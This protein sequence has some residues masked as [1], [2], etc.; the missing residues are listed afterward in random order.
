[1]IKIA[2]LLEK[3]DGVVA[4]R[5]HDTGHI[6]V[7]D[8]ETGEVLRD[9]PRG[10]WTDEELARWVLREDCE[11]IITGPME[12]RPFEIVAEEGMITRY[13][14]VGRRAPE[15]VRQMNACAL[16]LIPDYEGGVG[17]GAGGECH[18]HEH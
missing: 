6:C 16:D 1:M 5:F 15:A 7:M 14:G 10:D 2:C 11:A 12:R 18:G 9:F 3:K 17:C 13:N 8:A 4:W